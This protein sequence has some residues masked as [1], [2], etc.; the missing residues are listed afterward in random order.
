MG[1]VNDKK[2]PHDTYVDIGKQLKKD[3]Q[4]GIITEQQ[5]R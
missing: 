2:S 3:V 4:N 1:I 5:M